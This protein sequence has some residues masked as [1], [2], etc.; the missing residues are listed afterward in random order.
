MRN[1]TT[2][3][4]L[5]WRGAPALVRQLTGSTVARLE[6][7]EFPATR[8]RH[9]DLVAWLADQRLFHLE[10]QATP[11]RRLDWR[12]LEYYGPLSERNAGRPVFQMVLALTDAAAAVPARIEH[13]TLRFSYTV[14]NVRDLDPAPLLASDQ[15]D[16]ALL[17]ILCGRDDLRERVRGILSRLRDL[18]ERE[19][20][21]AV[22]RL[23]VLAGLR[24]A[25][26]LVAEETK[27][28][29]LQIDIDDNEFLKGVFAKGEAKGKAK[30]KAETL[31]RLLERRFHSVPAERRAQILA[32]EADRI[33]AWLDAVL[34]ADNLEAVF[35][36]GAGAH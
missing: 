2:L 16:D 13:P 11:H 17:A 1:D 27:A 19:R 28:M 15:P 14:V 9:P 8:N 3:K 22:A 25:E 5:L 30:G 26:R 7:T 4:D 10:L 31:V 18:D 34:E 21:D 32:A 35:T 29:A 12:M 33:D 23:F 6:P 36:P 20:T 24:K